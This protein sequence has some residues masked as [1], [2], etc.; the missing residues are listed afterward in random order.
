[1]DNSKQQQFAQVH[2][3]LQAQIAVSMDPVTGTFKF[4]MGEEVRHKK[5][6]GIYIITGLPNEYVLEHSREPAYT[7]LMKDGRTCVRS[8][9]EMEDGRFVSVSAG[10]AWKYA[11]PE[12]EI[13]T[14]PAPEKPRLPVADAI[15]FDEFVEY[16]KANGGN[17]V[18]GMPWSFKYKN[19]GVT[20]ENDDCY[21]VC[22][23][24]GSL[25]FRRGEVLATNWSTGALFT[26]NAEGF[27]DTFVVQS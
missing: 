1:V 9:T 21:I 19:H 14:T 12:T 13:S 10:T 23:P 11:L 7:Y 8:Q 16:G 24:A 15:T 5:S 17:I 6:G 4:R 2:P 27:D 25:M 18:N 20:H 22:L 26:C 3:Y